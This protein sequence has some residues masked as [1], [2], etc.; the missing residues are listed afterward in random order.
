MSHNRREK[1]AEYHPKKR[2]AHSQAVAHYFVSAR[3]RPLLLV[4]EFEVE[5][6]VGGGMREGTRT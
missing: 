4:F 1:G 2:C 5:I 3:F 6:S